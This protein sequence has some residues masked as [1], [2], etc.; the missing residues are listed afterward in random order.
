[1][2]DGQT[3]NKIVNFKDDCPTQIPG[4]ETNGKFFCFSLRK[5]VCFCLEFKL[6]TANGSVRLGLF[7]ILR[8]SYTIDL[9]VMHAGENIS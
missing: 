9:L 4:N 3:R 8:R 5:K 7:Q 1:M 6:S 2:F